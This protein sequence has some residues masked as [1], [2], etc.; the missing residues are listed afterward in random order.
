[1]TKITKVDPATPPPRAQPHVQEVATL[2]VSGLAVRHES[3]GHVFLALEYPLARP[4]MENRS[5]KTVEMIHNYV[6]TPRSAMLLA[7]ELERAAQ[8]YLDGNGGEMGS[9]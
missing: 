7:R 2:P 9:R 8:A 1:M 3:S 4:K 6:L 5:E